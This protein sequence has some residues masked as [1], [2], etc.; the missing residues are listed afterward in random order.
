VLAVFVER[1]GADGAQLAARQHRLEHIRSVHRSLGSTGADDR[2]QLVDEEDHC[3]GGVG[4]FLQDGL[5]PFL[6]FPSKLRPCDEGTQIQRDD[7]LVLKI[8]GNVSTHD[9]LRQ[10]L[11]DGR[12]ADARFADQYRVVLG[13]AREHLHDAADFLIAPDD[14]IEL[15]FP[16]QLCQVT[17]V[18]L[19]RL[20]LVFR[21]GI[22]HP[23]S[24]ANLRQSLVD[25]VLGYPEAGQ[26][27]RR[28][29]IDAVENPKQ[30]V[31]GADVFIAHPLG[32][33]LGGLERFAQAVADD[34]LRR[35]GELWQAVNLRGDSSAYRCW[36]DFELFQNLGN[37]PVRL[38]EQRQKERD[39]LELRDVSRLGLPL[40]IDDRFLS[41][42]RESCGARHHRF[43]PCLYPTGA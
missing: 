37:E 34:G 30:E 23:L 7:L 15:A 26:E 4:D 10:S 32:F 25:T 20:I 14:W 28:A 36:V 11:S 9:A 39:G 27:L 5:E 16:R 3:S 22:G 17:A 38:V 24:S 1:G 42:L 43:L 18:L 12:L 2:M 41:L 13:A 40:G 33:I 21:I 6:E 19:E 31:L 35:I 8:L 29:T